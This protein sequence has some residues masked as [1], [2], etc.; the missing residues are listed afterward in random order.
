MLELA[1][2]YFYLH[3]TPSLQQLSDRHRAC[4]CENQFVNTIV[5]GSGLNPLRL[6]STTVWEVAYSATVT[7]QVRYIQG[8]G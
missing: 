3:V 8:V 4:L 2:R 1:R 7:Q 5:M 6:S